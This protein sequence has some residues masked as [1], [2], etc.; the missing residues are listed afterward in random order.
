MDKKKLIYFFV[1][2]FMIQLVLGAPP[3]QT[4]TILQS[5]G[6]QIETTIFEVVPVS[7]NYSFH[8]HVFDVNGSMKTNASTFCF[9]HIYDFETGHHIV[10]KNATMDSNKID[11]VVAINS[12]V[13]TKEGTYFR[14]IQCN[15]SNIGGFLGT[16]FKVGFNTR[17]ATIQDAI[18]NSSILLLITILFLTCLIWGI[19]MDGENKFT[20][21][22]EGETLLELNI[23]K[24]A[25]LLLYWLAY[26]FFWMLI[27][28][29]WQIVQ[30]FMLSNTF[31]GIL[32]VLFI[33]L[34][35]FWIPLTIVIVVI[36]LVKHV[37]DSEVTRMVSRGLK[38]R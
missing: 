18:I 5:N 33:F 19:V 25:K 14:L 2:L 24:Y 29:A 37:T 31:S 26:M 13:L 28:V 30:K 9:L 17:E 23:G 27:W 38:P 7:S 1:F 36:G 6:L 3:F 11:F 22:P 34:T 20:M 8:W 32:K 10:E 15:S 35:I 16:Q 4:G 12:S 21:G